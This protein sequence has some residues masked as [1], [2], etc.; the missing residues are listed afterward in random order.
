MVDILIKKP[1]YPKSTAPQV[2]VEGNC[3]CWSEQEISLSDLKK[4]GEM[5]KKP[6]CEEDGPQRSGWKYREAVGSEPLESGQW[7]V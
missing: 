5:K 4:E 7:Q 1:K 2:G 3:Y 6:W